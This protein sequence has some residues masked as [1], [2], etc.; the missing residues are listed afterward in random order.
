MEEAVDRL[1]D[2]Y[3]TTTRAA[4]KHLRAFPGQAP[5]GRFAD[6]QDAFAWLDAEQ[7][8]LITAVAHAAAIQRHTHTT[9]I[10][11]CLVAYLSWQQPYTDWRTI[12]EHAL[13]AYQALGDRRGEAMAWNDLGYARSDVGC[14][15]AAVDAFEEARD[16]YRELGDRRGEAEFWHNLGGTQSGFARNEA[17]IDAYEKARDIYHDLG[18]LH[19]VARSWRCLG[20]A[21]SGCLEAAVDAFEKARDVYRELGDRRGEAMSWHNL[22]VVVH[23]AGR[24]EEARAAA[25]Q[26]RQAY[27][28]AGDPDGAAW[29]P[30]W[31][32]AEHQ[33]GIS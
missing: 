29:V 2:F 6:L 16:I 24:V 17:A 23:E 18:D 9:D 33:A 4:F 10:A 13:N 30:D 28:D 31:G 14:L 25:R 11:N 27:L 12:A 1:L 32:P 19:G 15:E 3:L 5:P 20:L 8:I 22:S 26:A 21:Q 7:A